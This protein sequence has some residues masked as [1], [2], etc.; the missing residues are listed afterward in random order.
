MG[1][2][3]MTVL[4]RVDTVE[5]ISGWGEAIAMWPEAC[6]AAATLVSEGFAR[7]IGAGDVSVESAWEIMR[8]H[9]WWYG[10]G[11][12]ACFAY[13]AIDIALGTCR[14]DRRPS[15]IRTF[16]R[17]GETEASCV[18]QQS[19]EQRYDR[20]L[21]ERGRRLLRAG[22]SQHEARLCQ[23]RNLE[24]RVRSRGRGRVRGGASR[25]ASGRRR[26]TGRLSATAW[27]GISKPVSTASAS[28]PLTS[29]VGSR[30]LSI[31]PISKRTAPYARQFDIPIATG[32]REWTVTGYERLIA[33][34]T[35]DIVGVDPGAGRGDHRISER[36]M[37]RRA[38]R[39]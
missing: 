28:S 29:P 9:S 6:K 27:L 37:R 13:S 19:R 39:A 12:V 8:A 5:G 32:E 24:H 1:H 31:P 34:G 10:E 23:E 2:D 38:R 30:S 33:T 25:E 15:V 14:E 22:F 7:L 26:D 3:R 35:V 4:V 20:R 18:R 21:R 16:R 11:G 17:S 36:S